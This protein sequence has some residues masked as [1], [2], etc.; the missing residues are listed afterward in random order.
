MSRDQ[1]STRR[2]QRSAH[3]ALPIRL[4]EAHL[5]ER[6]VGHGFSE[7]TKTSSRKRAQHGVEQGAHAHAVLSTNVVSSTNEGDQISGANVASIRV[8]HAGQELYPTM[9]PPSSVSPPWP[10]A[11]KWKIAE[12]CTWWRTCT[13]WARRRWPRWQPRPRRTTCVLCERGRR[14]LEGGRG[15]EGGCVGLCAVVL[16]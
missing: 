8:V 5:R 4:D 15:G 3:V 1:G 6:I 12:T 14:G 7:W 16:W 10:G 13:C 2:R 11:H 9:N